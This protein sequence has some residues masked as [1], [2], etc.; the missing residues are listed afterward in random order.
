MSVTVV[1]IGGVWQKNEEQRII[2]NSIGNVQIAANVLQTNLIEGL[3]INLDTPVTVL[4]EIFIGAYPSLYKELFIHGGK[5]NHSD[6]AEHT[7]YNIGFV[8]LPLYKHYSRYLHLKKYLSKV[9]RSA[10]TDRIYIIGYSMTYFIVEGLKY[11]KKK[12]PHVH[13]C[14]VVPDLPQFMYLG[15]KR[16]ELFRDKV[17]RRIRTWNNEKL[18]KDIHCI[19]SFVTLTKYIYEALHVNGSYTVVEGIATQ[20]DLPGRL[21][22]T[23]LETKDFVYTGTLSVKYGIIELVNAFTKIEGDDL[24]L[25][26]CGM[27]DGLGHIK[28]VASVDKR[29]QYKGILNNEE[30]RELQSNAYVL[31]NPRSSR[32]EYTKYSFPS[33][34]MEYMAAGRPVLMYKLSGIPDE[35]DD[36]LYYIND[37]IETSL[38]EM[39]EKDPKE[40]DE[41]GKAAQRFV[42]E[43]KNKAKQTKKIIDMLNSMP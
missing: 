4:S 9:C 1:F 19:D 33:K 36:Y 23:G 8:N 37:D 30:T 10:S 2:D 28:K 6:V 14:L 21:T 18:Y 13:T 38:R 17:E 11:S 32:E 35:Y 25:V 7:D 12:F 24:R 27:G 22:R 29:I 20:S 39:V 41:K 3:D 42:L 15:R 16:N 43:N 40:L 34:T 26:I 5:W 31:V